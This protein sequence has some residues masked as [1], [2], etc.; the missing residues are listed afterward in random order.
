MHFCARHGRPLSSCLTPLAAPQGEGQSMMKATLL[1]ALPDKE[2]ATACDHTLHH[3][4]PDGKLLGSWHIVQ[5]GKRRK[6]VCKVCG[7]FYGYLRE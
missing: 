1:P 2:T 3:A 6:V 4:N 5:A 7:R